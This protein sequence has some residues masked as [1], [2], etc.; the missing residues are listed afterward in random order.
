MTSS[1]RHVQFTPADFFADPEFL[2]WPA[3]LRGAY[4]SIIF[5][6][7]T[8][9]GSIRNDPA[10][11]KS[12]ANWTGE[13]WDQAWDSLR[14]KFKTKN[15]KIFHK[16]VS[17]ELR[18]AK[19]FRQN[20]SAA[21]VKG[22]TR[23]WQSHSSAMAQPM[24]ND[25]K[26]KV[27]KG[28]ERKEEKIPPVVPPQGDDPPLGNRVPYAEIARTWNEVAGKA[29][30][31]TVMRPGGLS[32]LRKRHLKR[33]WTEATFREQYRA[34]FERVAATPFLCGDNDRHWPATFDWIVKN[35]ENYVKVLEG[36]YDRG[37]KPK[38]TGPDARDRLDA[39]MEQGSND[40]AAD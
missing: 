32:E 9:D 26:G 14:V 18:R 24:A 11:L 16:R 35:A 21:G 38:P 30:L 25:S 34:I 33:R 5:C 40:R 3:D 7:Y 8:S 10:V 31:P 36:A 17:Q 13:N 37:S 4:C 20:R 39:L 15:G 29:G 28:K 27:R 6:L 1:I 2:S 22:A 19:E 12:I 23:R